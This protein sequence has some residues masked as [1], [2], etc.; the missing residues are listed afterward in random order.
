MSFEDFAGDTSL[1][2]IKYV[3]QSENSK[4]RRIIWSLVLIGALSC[5]GTQM[6]VAII[7]YYNYDYYTSIKTVQV[8]NIHFPSVTVCN[9]NLIYASSI[10]EWTS[11][12]ISPV[13]AI[14]DYFQYASGV[15]SP[16]N[17]TWPMELEHYK[18]ADFY[19]KVS[20]GVENFFLTCRFGGFPI[21]CTDYFTPVVSDKG[22][23]YTFNSKKRIQ[24]KGN[25]SLLHPGQAFGLDLVVNIA[26]YEYLS[27]STRGEGI[28]V[29]VH[30]PNALPYVEASSVF[31]GTGM[32]AFLAIDEVK[33]NRLSE[34][35]ST[36][37][38]TQEESLGTKF[39]QRYNLPYSEETCRIDCKFK[40]VFEC[41]ICDSRST[42]PD[43]C[44][45]LQFIQC[46]AQTFQQYYQGQH[47]CNCLPACE[48]IQYK[49]VVT[50]TTFP[51]QLQESDSRLFSKTGLLQMLMK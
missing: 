36:K 5:L 27:S 2:G 10:H 42:G 13:K 19:E 49:P 33:F 4:I 43:G 37:C 14:L 12:G 11:L 46:F 6:T 3:Y 31:V 16:E 48:E 38:I 34:P 17:I 26:P 18:Y 47:N 22:F 40:S 51:N 21:N 9:L 20:V 15:L 1:H 32:E 25:I 8:N 39:Y 28:R 29:I 30:Q 50:Y 23:C 24:E 41:G 44:T 35:Y 45:V 7:K